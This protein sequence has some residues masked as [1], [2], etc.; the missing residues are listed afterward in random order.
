M[1]LPAPAA[2]VS[3]IL[4]RLNVPPASPQAAFYTALIEEV[5]TAIAAADVIAA[6]P[7][8]GFTVVVAGAPTPVTGFGKVV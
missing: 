4:T 7:P 8:A 5:F 2:V 1:A 3:R 6:V